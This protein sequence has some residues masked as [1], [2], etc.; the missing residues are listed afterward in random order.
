MLLHARF[1][2]TLPGVALALA[3][4]TTLPTTAQAQR[5][6]TLLGRRG[7]SSIGGFGGPVVKFSRLAG[8]DAVFSGGRGGV[9]L[10]RRLAIGG[11]GYAVTSENIRTDFQF[12]DG[13]RPALQLAYGGIEFEYITRSR[14]LVHATVSLLLGGG[15]ASYR[16][17]ATTGGTVATRTLES[18]RLRGGAGGESRGERDALVPPG[19]RGGL[20]LRERQR[21]AGYHGRRA[22]RCSRHAHVQV[23]S[24]LTGAVGASPRLTPM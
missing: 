17:T 24:L 10:N 14:E 3:V 20:S 15:A 2:R 4:L 11:G 7:A 13:S 9:I 23:R 19:H 12:D 21:P 8:A 5:D 22:E 1:T 6:E 18:E 16:S